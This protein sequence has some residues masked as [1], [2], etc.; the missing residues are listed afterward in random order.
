LAGIAHAGAGGDENAR[1]YALEMAATRLR[2]AAFIG[3]EEGA[4]LPAA[5]QARSGDRTGAGA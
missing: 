4:A 1:I 2:I 5:A 3:A